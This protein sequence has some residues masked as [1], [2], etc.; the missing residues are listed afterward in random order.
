LKNR[1]RYRKKW[2]KYHREYERKAYKVFRDV[3][4][5]WSKNLD[6]TV[7]TALNYESVISNAADKKLLIEAYGK[8]YTSIGLKHAERIGT[9]L[10]K[11]PLRQKFFTLDDF[12]STFTDFI[13]NWLNNNKVTDLRNIRITY[14]ETIMR[15]VGKGLEEGK[16]IQEIATEI[17]RLINSP[18]FY[19][20][21]AMRIARTETTTA[22]N[23]ATLRTADNYG[24]RTVKE[25][26]SASD[27]RVRR[28]PQ[29]RYDHAI[30][31]GK[32]VEM[33]EVFSVPTKWGVDNLE[34]PGDPSGDPGNIINCRCTV[35]IV[36]KRDRDG[37][38]IQKPS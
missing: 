33:D 29:D 14:Q 16:T 23:L 21:Q 28:L 34:F 7:I 30:M 32:R 27:A 37:N 4:K 19:R 11:E 9:E 36:P 38:L 10:N 13:F 24:F 20:W 1:N 2:L 12:A 26:I 17:Q 18:R 5:Q 3:F 25:W 8:V 35:A 6:T 31:N 15:I 22:A